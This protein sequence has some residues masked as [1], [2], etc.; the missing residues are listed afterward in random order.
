MK[1]IHTTVEKKQFCFFSEHHTIQYLNLVTCPLIRTLL[2]IVSCHITYNQIIR[3]MKILSSQVLLPN[4]QHYK[5]AG[6]SPVT[7]QKTAQISEI[8]NQVNLSNW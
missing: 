3:S 6:E 2:L 4:P 1:K 7:L 8:L 5:Y